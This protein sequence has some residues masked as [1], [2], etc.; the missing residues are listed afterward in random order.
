[1][2]NV[3]NYHCTKN[4]KT[5]VVTLTPSDS[6]VSDDLFLRSLKHRTTTGN[7]GKKDWTGVKWLRYSSNLV[8]H[9]LDLPTKYYY[10]R[11]GKKQ[12]SVYS[13]VFEELFVGVKETLKVHMYSYSK[14]IQQGSL[15]F[16]FV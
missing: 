13:F 7:Y 9:D 2:L 14:E 1:M 8:G 12:K 15:S 3:K 4:D 6:Y 16:C 10:S 11:G 5:V